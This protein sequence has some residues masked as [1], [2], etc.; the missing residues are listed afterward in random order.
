M[1]TS[2]KT[3]H[4]REMA[5]DLQKLYESP[6]EKVEELQ[7]EWIQIREENKAIHSE[8]WKAYENLQKEI[9]TFL[10]EKKMKLYE[11]TPRGLKKPTHWFKL[12]HSNIPRPPSLYSNEMPMVESRNKSA[13]INGVEVPISSGLTILEAYDKI[14]KHMKREHRANH[15]RNLLIAA[16]YKFINENKIAFDGTP[17][18]AIGLANEAA[19]NKWM[20]ENYP[21]GTVVGIDDN[22]CECETYTIGEHWCSCGNRR[23][24]ALPEGNIVDGYYL[25]TEPH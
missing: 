23:I 17:G 18:Q 11:Y 2:F 8:N 10:T 19:G 3:Y 6:R 22:Y 20:Q 13:K 25:A 1:Y 14:H 21:N 9:E 7:K 4:Q 15:K 5:S 24:S 16:A 12:M